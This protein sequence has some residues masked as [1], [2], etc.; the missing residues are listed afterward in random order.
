MDK[1]S[2]SIKP[3]IVR[4]IDDLGRIVIPVEY[5]KT[6]GWGIKDLLEIS[7]T[8]EGVLLRKYAPGCA[9][10]CEDPNELISYRGRMVC[11]A[12]VREMSHLVME[13]SRPDS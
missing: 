5:R 7:A 9:C 13:G 2:I 6:M 8:N 1:V 10:G 12:C 3:N 4:K 11:K